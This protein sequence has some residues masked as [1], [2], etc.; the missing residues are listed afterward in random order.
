MIWHRIAACLRHSAFW[1]AA[2]GAA[3]V[4]IQNILLL[5]GLGL[6]ISG[7]VV[8]ANVVSVSLYLDLVGLAL[9]GIGLLSFTL[10]NPFLHK[11][12][13]VPR[14]NA[15]FG[16][17]AGILCLLWIG[18]TVAW[19][20]VGLRGLSSTA[21]AASNLASGSEEFASLM[22]ALFAQIHIV[23]VV[24]IA[25]SI[26]LAIAS[27]LL[28][29]FIERMTD[30]EVRIIAWPFFCLLSAVATVL[31]AGALIGLA[32]GEIDFSFLAMAAFLKLA[33]V[34]FFGIVAYSLLLCKFWHLARRTISL[35]ISGQMQE[36]AED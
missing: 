5:T 16:A 35:E 7:N 3:L 9:V 21:T 23:M 24:W 36:V 14:S 1:M 20:I 17:A 25:A 11:D 12:E 2:S 26:T 19:R 6:T 29:R 30:G 18:L 13:S 10:H 31:L 32:G 4:L 28:A 33:T 8:G 15:R 22:S 27:I 34:P